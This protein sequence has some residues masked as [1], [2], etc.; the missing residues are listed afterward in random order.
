MLRLALR[1]RLKLFCFTKFNSALKILCQTLSALA[2]QLKKK[3]TV[4][5]N[6]IHL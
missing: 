3:D 5:T 4:G 6:F 1:T 2:A